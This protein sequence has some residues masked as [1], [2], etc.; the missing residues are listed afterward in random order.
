MHAITL[1]IISL[2]LV[3]EGR[4]NVLFLG[5]IND[6]VSGFQDKIINPVKN[7]DIGGQLN[8]Y[9]AHPAQDF[10]VNFANKYK[11]IATNLAKPS[12]WENYARNPYT[13]F[14]DVNSVVNPYMTAAETAQDVLRSRIPQAGLVLDQLDQMNPAKTGDRLGTKYG[15]ESGW[16]QNIND[17]K[18]NPLNAGLSLGEDITDAASMIPGEGV[19][20]AGLKAGAKTGLKSGLKQGGRV[21]LKAAKAGLAARDIYEG[22][23]EGGVEGG[24]VAGVGHA[25]HFKGGKNMR[26]IAKAAKG[27]A[28]GY[29]VYKAANNG[30]VEGAIMS[31][32]AAAA[33]LKG[34]KHAKNVAKGAKGVMAGVKIYKATS[35]GG[36]E[37]GLRSGLRQAAKLNGGK[38][39]RKAAKGAQAAMAGWDIYKGAQKGGIEGALTSGLEGASKFKG[40]KNAKKLATAAKGAMS[41]VN[42]IKAG[43][44]GGIEGG[45][46][47]ALMSG[48]ENGAQMKDLFKTKSSKGQRKSNKNATK[49]NQRQ[50]RTKKSPQNFGAAVKKARKR[51]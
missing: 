8:K 4:R 50:Q 5:F 25:A 44:E 28:A 33:K 23:R 49:N 29:E 18:S 6:A 45:L 15:T 17:W 13:A 46:E 12:T 24:L 3:I 42:I 11:N 32:A 9:V 20:A 41:A 26:N 21:A 35:R 34:G 10:G 48:M 31:G 27:V 40:G 51:R 39:A 19:A 22:A 30:D 16:K 2:A 1:L 7:A 43:Q 37:G 38:N 47:A 14:K 36:V